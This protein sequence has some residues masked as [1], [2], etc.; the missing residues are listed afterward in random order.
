MIKILKSFILLILLVGCSTYD[1]NED[2]NETSSNVSTSDYSSSEYSESDSPSFDIDVTASSSSNY[3]L[4]GT[5]RNGNVSG[6]DPDLSFKVGDKI[7]FDVTAVGHPFYLKTS[8][9]TGTSDTISGIINNGTENGK[10]TWKPTKTGTFYY[11][12]SLH[13]GMVGTI[14]IE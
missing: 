11:I 7:N 9:S 3:T 14:T 1:N 10:I 4:S 2:I 5:D 8:S 12:C 6:N 13:G